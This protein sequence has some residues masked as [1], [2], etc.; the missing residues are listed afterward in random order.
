MFL[1]GFSFANHALQYV[2]VYPSVLLMCAIK[3]GNKVDG[4]FSI[5]LWML[6]LI[7]KYNSFE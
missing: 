7:K 2:V 1:I 5:K 6:L 4:L 3:V